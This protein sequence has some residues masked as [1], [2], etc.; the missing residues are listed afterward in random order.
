ME[1]NGKTT[2]FIEPEKKLSDNEK[3]EMRLFD[4]F[5]NQHSNLFEFFNDK[6]AETNHKI[7][8]IEEQNRKLQEQVNDLEATLK[9]FEMDEFRHLEVDAAASAI[10]N[11]EEE[12]INQEI[13]AL[14]NRAEQLSM[15]EE[16]I[17]KAV[18]EAN[19]AAAT[20]EEAIEEEVE[21]PIV[22]AVEEANVAATVEEAIEEEVEDPTVEAVEEVEA[23]TKTIIITNVLEK[24]VIT[25]NGSVK[26]SGKKF[27]K[28]ITRNFLSFIDLEVEK[29]K[30]VGYINVIITTNEFTTFEYIIKNKPYLEAGWYVFQDF[31]AGNLETFNLRYKDIENDTIAF[32]ELTIRN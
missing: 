17:V 32:Y 27:I 16:P 31:L 11:A 12:P 8:N 4:F 2:D 26:E 3:M 9:L 21:E 6:I 7:N 23:E 10:V 19:V 18:E 20:V 5:Y 15:N 30:E 24:G 29:G 1:E 25:Y 28:A 13:E 22:K 14:I